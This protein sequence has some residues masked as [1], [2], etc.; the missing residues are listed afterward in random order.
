MI[1]DILFNYKLG[2]VQLSAQF[3][4]VQMWILANSI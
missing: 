3:A 1:V 2:L 4:E